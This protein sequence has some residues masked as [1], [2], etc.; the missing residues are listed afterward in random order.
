MAHLTTSARGVF[1]VAVTPFTDTLAVDAGSIDSVVDF[2]FDKGADGLTVLGMMGEAPKLA[3]EE[4][5]AG[6]PGAR[7]SHARRQV[8]V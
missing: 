8:A 7:S 6:L 3:H 4:A 5:V 1:V 2:Y